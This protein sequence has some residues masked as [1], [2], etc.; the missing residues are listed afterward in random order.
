MPFSDWDRGPWNRWSFQHVREIVPTALVSRNEAAASALGEALVDFCDLTFSING[1]KLSVRKWLDESFTDGFLVI[2]DGTILAETYMNGMDRTSLHLVQSVSK[3]IT[4]AAAGALVEDGRLDPDKIVTH[5]LPELEKTAYAGARVRHVL[6]MTSGTVFDETY[7]KPDWHCAFLDASAGWKQRTNESWPRT[8]FDLILRLDEREAPH[9]AQF[10]YR[11]IETDV[12]A[13][14]ME[15]ASGMPLNE[16]VT[17]NVWV[18]MGAERD[19]YFTV[20]PSGYASADGGFNASLRDLGRFGLM[21]ARRGKVDDRQVIPEAWVDDCLR[22]DPAIFDDTV[23]SK[24]AYR[25]QFW[26]EEAGKPIL[27]CRG[28]FGQIVYI[29][30]EQCFVAVKL[31]SWPEFLNAKRTSTTLAAMRAIRDAG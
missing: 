14:C 13:H 16:L 10:N 23:L 3:S 18:P 21:M 28:V 22:G 1:E 12:L 6:D 7:T 19:A 25:N 9:G 11:S 17:R 30:I 20:D 26:I 8:V 29:D 15:R 24:G 31:S 5:Y 2:R 4:A 27:I